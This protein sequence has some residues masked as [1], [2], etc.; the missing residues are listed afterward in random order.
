MT[1]VGRPGSPSALRIQNRTRVIGALRTH[2]EMTQAA[3]ARQTGLAPA[4]VSNIVRELAADGDVRVAAAG[5]RARR[6]RLAAQTGNV[7]GVDYGHRHVT[8]AVSDHTHRILAERRAELDT[9]ITAEAGLTIAARLVDAAMAAAGIDRSAVVGAG[10]GLPAPIDAATGIVG[11]PSILPG[12]VGIRAGEL[13][14]AA[15]DLPVRMRVDNDANLGALAEH[16]WGGGVGVADMAY[17]KLSDGVGAGLIV[18]GTVYSGASGTAGEIGHTTIDEFGDVCRCGNRGCLETLV[19]ARRVISLLKSTGE[20]P[21]RTISEVVRRA[22]TGDRACA[23][24]LE[25]VGHQV[26]RAVADLCSLLNP[27][28]LLVGG[29]LGQ[30]APLLIPAIR[31]VVLRCGVP[32]AAEQLDIRLGRLGARTHVYGAIALAIADADGQLTQ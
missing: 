20:S 12:W 5:G 4:T 1:P 27:S 7:I 16:R 22:D 31:Q 25:D 23:R 15:M 14:T 24:V 9:G 17:L 10:M 8:V 6:V 26:G 21:P 29:E 2:G 28:L 13:A 30:A 32:S 11:S 19:S 3:L 18:G